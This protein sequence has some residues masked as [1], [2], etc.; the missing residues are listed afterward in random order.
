MLDKLVCSYLAT[1]ARNATCAQSSARSRLQQRTS[2]YDFVVMECRAQ[3]LRCFG[4]GLILAVLRLLLMV[5]KKPLPV[6]FL[7]L[8]WVDHTT[9]LSSC[10][11]A[12]R[13]SRTPC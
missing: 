11:T 12:T 2:C 9:M 6:A 10:R 8:I 5:L 7:N 13:L 1:L 3:Q 4:L